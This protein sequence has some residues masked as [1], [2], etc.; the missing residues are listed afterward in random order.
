MNFISFS[1]PLVAITALI[2]SIVPWVWRFCEQRRKSR[3]SAETNSLQA[4]LPNSNILKEILGRDHDTI[5]ADDRISYQQRIAGW[6]LKEVALF[7][8]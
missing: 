3:F 7:L 2:L 6:D 1:V 5:L 4:F 8:G